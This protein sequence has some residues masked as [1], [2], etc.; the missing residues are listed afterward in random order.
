M[1]EAWKAPKNPNVSV[2]ISSKPVIFRSNESNPEDAESATLSRYFQRTQFCAAHR[3]FHDSMFA[4]A[5]L[6]TLG[7][8]IFAV[9]MT[10]LALD[11]RLRMIMITPHLEQGNHLRERQ[12]LAVL[13]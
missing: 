13:S 7:D 8:G 1:E 9:A 6:D 3:S 5:R 2:Q 11:I 4:N 12:M 10:S